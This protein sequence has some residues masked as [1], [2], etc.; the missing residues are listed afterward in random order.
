MIDRA[1][2][3]LLGVGEKIL[4]PM[5]GSGRRRY[6]GEGAPLT[7]GWLRV[8]FEAGGPHSRRLWKADPGRANPL[9][10][11]RCCDFAT[12]QCGAAT[13]RSTDNFGE[14]GLL[15][16]DKWSSALF[17][18]DYDLSDFR[19]VEFIWR[20][21]PPYP[22]APPASAD[23]RCLP[24]GRRKPPGNPAPSSSSNSLSRM[25]GADLSARRE[26]T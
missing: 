14:D 24:T 16:K 1:R 10:R 21:R 26:R 13:R 5:E 9:A 11:P 15:P 6:A 20:L 18:L 12:L 7:S 19:I 23:T 3:A 2:K 4:V 17:K 25:L 22:L 8:V